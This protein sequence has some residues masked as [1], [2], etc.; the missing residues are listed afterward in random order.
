M[1]GIPT[2]R[3][4][5]TAGE[6]VEEE[7]AAWLRGAFGVEGTEVA[8]AWGQLELGG[9]VRI[10]GLSDAPPLPDCG[11]TI[12]DVDGVPVPAGETGEVVLT[13]PW[14]ATMVGVE[15]DS[16]RVAEAHWTRHPG[17]YATGDLGRVDE[18]GLVQFLGRT[19]D[20]VSISGQLVSLRE[21]REVLTEHP[22]VDRA[23]V[24]WRKD[25]ELGR[26][27]VAAVTLSGAAASSGGSG[28]PAGG[29]GSAGGTGSAD[30]DAIAVDLM[31][32]VRELLGGLARPRA[33][34]VVDRFG[35]ELGRRERAQAIATLATPDRLGAPRSV[36][37]E[38]VLVAAGH[39]VG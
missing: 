22:Y 1:S 20:V 13:R 3:R 6:P 39:P 34:L 31:D 9:I 33:L 25:P 37:W 19:D 27:L 16:A 35:E 38:Q 10:T 30:L 7:L 23:E 15:G 11:L 36:T 24:T 2:L 4:V 8:D 28:G 32:T 12:V 17:V 18:D 21:V 5:A 26:S 29:A 14:A